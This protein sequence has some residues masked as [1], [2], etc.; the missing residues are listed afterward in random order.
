MRRVKSRGV[1]LDAVDEE[2]GNLFRV[3]FLEEVDAGLGIEQEVVELPH[4]LVGDLA[5]ETGIVEGGH[6][7]GHAQGEGADALLLVGV[8]G[9]EIVECEAARGKRPA[10]GMRR[11]ILEALAGGEHDGLFRVGAQRRLVVVP[12]VAVGVLEG[13]SQ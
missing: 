9:P 13:A 2:N 8:A 6:L 11:S 7:A 10:S 4:P 1:P 3:V 5:V 12:A